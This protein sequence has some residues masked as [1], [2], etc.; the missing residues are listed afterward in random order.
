MASPIFLSG[1]NTSG[2][3]D[4]R[5]DLRCGKCMVVSHSVHYSTCTPVGMTQNVDSRD[6]FYVAPRRVKILY[7]LP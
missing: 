2:T 4:E 3:T 7:V 6:Y 1:A 5:T